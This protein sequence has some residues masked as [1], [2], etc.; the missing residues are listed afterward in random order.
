MASRQAAVEHDVLIAALGFGQVQGGIGLREQVVIG[1]WVGSGKGDSDASG[2]GEVVPGD[3]DR[4][5]HQADEG[6]GHLEHPAGTGRMVEQHD[7]LV[8]RQPGDQVARTHGARESIGDGDEQPIPGAMTEE[9]VHH[10][11]LVE[12]EEEDGGEVAEV[13]VRPPIE[14]VQKGPAV[15]EIREL[16]VVGVVGETLFG[17]DPGLELDYERRHR[18]QGVGLRRV[19]GSVSE[20]DE[21][22]DADGCRVANQ[23]DH[24]HGDL[25]DPGAL[26]HPF[27]IGVRGFCG[28]H[29]ERLVEIAGGIEDRIDPERDLA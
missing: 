19:P 1:R 16:V 10:L 24:G 27:L 7:E 14:L 13:L 26:L 23:G 28:S 3:L 9:V 2:P 6:L 20:L 5:G 22:E 17:V 11:E 4:L 29:H 18:L 12:V 15:R 8:A 21:A 25:A